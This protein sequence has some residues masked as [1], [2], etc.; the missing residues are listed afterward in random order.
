MAISHAILHN[1]KRER[2]IQKLKNEKHCKEVTKNV[3]AVLQKIYKV[4]R[5]STNTRCWQT[6]RNG[7]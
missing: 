7:R 4:W 5:K 2:K 6:V 1:E 3:R